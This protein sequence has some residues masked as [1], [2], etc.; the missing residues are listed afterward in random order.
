MKPE[1]VKELL[2]DDEYEEGMTGGKPNNEIWPTYRCLERLALSRQQN[3]EKKRLL[4]ETKSHLEFAKT[5]YWE[6][7]NDGES[8]DV[9]LELLE[10]IAKAIDTGGSN[11]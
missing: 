11:E 7:F 6:E 3:A 9:I 4:E 8:H 5:T 2:R 10:R 1:Q